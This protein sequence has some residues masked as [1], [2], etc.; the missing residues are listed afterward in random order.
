MRSIITATVTVL[1]L[2]P[3]VVSADQFSKRELE[4]RRH[5]HQT[6][7]FCNTWKCVKRVTR[8]REKRQLRLESREMSGYRAHPMPWCTWGPESGSYRPQWSMA[9]YRQPNVSG[10]D[11]GGKFQILDRTWGAY[12]GRAYAAHAYWARPVHQERIARRVLAGQGLGAW[13]NC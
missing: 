3:S 6:F 11:G 5:V 1:L 12:G 8:I 7:N 10:G 2:A 13:S 9:R 4:K